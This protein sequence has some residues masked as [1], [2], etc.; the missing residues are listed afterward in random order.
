MVA[1]AEKKLGFRLPTAY[2][3]ILK[4][5]NGGYPRYD[6]YGSDADF[7]FLV[8]IAGIGDKASAGNI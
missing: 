2:L 4:L 7:T 6:A 1:A 3:A 5:Q 8:G